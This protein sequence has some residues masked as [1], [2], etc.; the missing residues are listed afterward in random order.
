MMTDRKV[1]SLC[2][3]AKGTHPCGGNLYLQVSAPGRASWL[4]RF[5]IKHKA[6]G[7]G[8]GSVANWSLAEARARAKEARQLLDD[9]I[10]PLQ[11]RLVAIAASAAAASMQKTFDAVAAE[12][13]ATHKV[14]W[15]SPRH[16]AAWQNSLK[17]FASP[18]IGSMS[19]DKITKHHMKE[20]LAPI[21]TD[22]YPTATRL[23]E[24][25][26]KIMAHDL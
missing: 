25:L 3:G 22:H 6:R 14:E 11:H 8:L 13:I 18:V 20:I 26:E 9:G 16:L 23:R 4:F 1:K 19:V 24:R 2:K 21:W 17:R 10:D 12:Y 5:M 7:M 15:S